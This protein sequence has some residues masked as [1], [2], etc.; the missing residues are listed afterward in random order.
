MAE[1]AESNSSTSN[2]RRRQQIRIDMTPMVDLAFLLL[3]FFVLAATLT[4]P[5]SM[6]IIYPAD[7]ERT[8]ANE[9]TVTTILLGDEVNEVAYYRGLFNQDSTQLIP[10]DFSPNGLRKVL[11]AINKERISALDQLQKKRDDNLISEENYKA[12]Y[13]NELSHMNA[14]IVVVKTTAG[15]KYHVLINV[16]DELNIA[17]IRKRVVQDMTAE[18]TQ[19]LKRMSTSKIAH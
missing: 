7:G 18:E 15:T 17:G 1:I 4:K 16:M 8:P 6:E 13:S 11:I 9:R 10:T 3:T 14:P 2:R 12:E 19:H 5:K